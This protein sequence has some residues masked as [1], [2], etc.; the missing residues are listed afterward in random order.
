V[1]KIS[2]FKFQNQKK[3]E[4]EFEIEIENLKK[5]INFFLKSNFQIVRVFRATKMFCFI[6]DTLKTKSYL[7]LSLSTDC[8]YKFLVNDR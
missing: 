8:T 6:F 3:I 7:S 4:I 5:I 1:S 2:N